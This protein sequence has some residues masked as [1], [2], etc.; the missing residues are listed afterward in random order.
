MLAL[1]SSS[2]RS[3][4][5][6]LRAGGQLLR[7]ARRGRHAGGAGTGRY[8]AAARVLA[9]RRRHA[10]GLARR[11]RQLPARARPQVCES[12]LHA[13]NLRC[14]WGGRLPERAHWNV[15]FLR[16]HGLTH[17]VLAW[18][19]AHGF[20][21]CA[22]KYTSAKA[23]REFATLLLPCQSGSCCILHCLGTLFR[24]CTTARAPIMV[25]S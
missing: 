12:C 18:P 22:Y 4:C 7:R 6:R 8:A 10:A 20:G 9:A 11:R 25:Q 3:A 21:V 17:V 5:L 2:N 14:R 23:C 15:L 24:K 13:L 16:A 19:G 1:P